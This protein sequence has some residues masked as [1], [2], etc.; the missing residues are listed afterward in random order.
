MTQRDDAGA[1]TAEDRL[2]LLIDRLLASMDGAAAAGSWPRVLELADDVLAVD[3]GN[4]RATTLVKRARSEQSLPEGERAFVSLL[5]ADIV[6]STDLADVT[7]PETVRHVF[8]LY[9]QVATEVV[10]EL[11]G[12]VLQFQGDAVIACFGYPNVHEDDARRAVLAGLRLLDRMA[13]ASHELRRR[14]QIEPAIRVGIHSGTVVVTG[15][16][17][18]AVDA[19]DIVGSAANVA[20][21]LQGEAE[22]GTL[23]ISDATRQ[24]VEPHFETEPA[25][26]RLLRGIARPIGI[27]RV[28][29]STEAF[30]TR[31]HVCWRVRVSPRRPLNGTESTSSAPDRAPATVD[32]RT[33]EM[34]I[35]RA[36][37]RRS[38][39]PAGSTSKC[40]STS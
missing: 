38:R 14:Y 10:E 27:F 33:R 8:T 32:R 21:R 20:A 16:A 12:R 31:S 17:S 18:G 36:I 3:P 26:E 11:D 22:A 23:V 5:F 37:P 34:P 9:R 19:A 39:S 2:T 28:L 24:L 35:G 6:K 7:E 40:G 4:R 30:T 13:D 15:L 25:G 1:G 29:R